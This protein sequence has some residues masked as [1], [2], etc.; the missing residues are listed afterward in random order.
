MSR[1][2]RVA[3]RCTR[4][5]SASNSGLG[6]PVTGAEVRR[7]FELFAAAFPDLELYRRLAQGCAADPEVAGLLTAA[8]AGQ[9]RP[10]LLF[11]AVH[12][13]VL[14]DPSIE[15]ARWYR[16]VTPAAD[17]ARS[18][19][20]PVFRATALDHA[21]HLRDVIATHA[22]QTNEVN[23]S[24]LLAVL[25]SA[26][27]ADQAERPVALVELGT[28]AGLLLG[29]DRYCIEVGDA[30]V[31]DA[32]S[33]VRLAGQVRGTAQPDL[34]AFPTTIAQ[35]TGIDLDPVPLDDSE[36]VRWLEAC[37]WPDQPWRVERFRAAVTLMRSDPPDLVS[38]DFVDRLGEVAGETSQDTHL[39]VFSTWALTYVARGRRH[40]IERLLGAC[41]SSGRPVSW[42]T[43]EPP[44]CVPGIEPPPW[45]GDHGPVGAGEAEPET[46]QPD[47][48]LGL[49]RWRNRHALEPGALGWSHPHG[50]WLR[51]T[52]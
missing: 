21:E 12:D 27:C 8:R 39:I 44:G 6:T 40:E 25:C 50:N 38:G 32:S 42:L 51:L 28:S 45:E 30:I 10:V 14:A 35:R 34:S 46:S 49:H 9:E 31:G 47:T 41:A 3:S 48:V 19:P 17:L 29:I 52:T 15:L 1:C 2:T 11:A 18:D 37:L 33:P 4:T 16:S 13:L 20:W 5:S 23:R 26:A 7:H 24:V 22:T 36:A 43:A